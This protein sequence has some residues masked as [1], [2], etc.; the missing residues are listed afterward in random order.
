MGYKISSRLPKI[1][2]HHISRGFSFQLK[3]A[4]SC[5]SHKIQ[6]GACIV[7][8]CVTNDISD[9]DSQKTVKFNLNM[10]IVI[11]YVF[12]IISYSWA[13]SSP[14]GNTTFKSRRRNHWR[15]QWWHIFHAVCILNWRREIRP[16]NTHTQQRHEFSS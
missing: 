7:T 16:K 13:S 10:S 12:L 8:R 3:I 2:T 15:A 4:T 9:L 6:Y 1:D 5:P 14:C 11:T